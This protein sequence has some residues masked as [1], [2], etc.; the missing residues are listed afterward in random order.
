MVLKNAPTERSIKIGG[1]REQYS[2]PPREPSE[3]PSSDASPQGSQD[4]RPPERTALSIDSWMDAALPEAANS[5]Y[6]LSTSPSASN[7]RRT[8][9]AADA[10]AVSL[11]LAVTGWD[12]SVVSA[13]SR[14]WSLI[15][16][17]SSLRRLDA[18]LMAIQ[19]KGPVVA[20]DIGRNLPA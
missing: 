1:G 10:L 15:F 9:S 5:L 16:R 2:R 11:K 7:S 3:E 18:S 4:T 8:P 19:V 14:N 20:P 12:D 13:P 17:K 6:F